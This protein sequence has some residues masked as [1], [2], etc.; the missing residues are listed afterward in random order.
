M[1]KN[2]PPPDF[3]IILRLPSF[4][5]SKKGVDK[6]Y[7]QYITYLLTFIKLQEKIIV[8]LLAIILGKS[9]AR[10]LYDEPINKPYQKL[11]VDKMPIIEKLEKLDHHQLLKEY[12]QE[13][14]KRLKPVQRRKNS[15]VKVPE[16]LTCPRCSAPRSE[17]H[18]SELQSRGHIV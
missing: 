5:K 12:E 16:S 18:T 1:Q 15:L 8:A 2:L 14:G 7:S 11:I 17:E 3:R 10:G 6:L 9:V 4:K 13:H